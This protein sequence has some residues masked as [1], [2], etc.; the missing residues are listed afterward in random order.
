MKNKPFYVS[1]SG[2][3]G[4]GKTT[5]ARMIA[6]RF[7][8]ESY[9]ESIGYENDQL[10]QFYANKKQNSFKFQVYLLDKR[11]GQQ[12]AITTKQNGTLIVEDRTLYEDLIFA[13]ILLADHD[14]AE[15]Q[16]NIYTD[17]HTKV[18]DLL[19]KPDMIIHLDTTPEM[20]LERIQNRGREC[21]KGITI[22]Y[23]QKL[24]E[25][26]KRFIPRMVNLGIPV[27]VIHYNNFTAIS[28]IFE[29]IEHLLATKPLKTDV[30]YTNI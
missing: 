11:M 22:E 4:A 17:L 13:E 3:I 7:D 2:N 14:M 10:T 15:D 19:Q 8:G 6:Q 18:A 26:Y 23:L 1:I 27:K 5:S 21:E 28:S 9:H 12:I 24:D 30:H 25:G 29:E 20:C 16:F